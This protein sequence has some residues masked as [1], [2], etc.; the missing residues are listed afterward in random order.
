MNLIKKFI[1]YLTLGFKTISTNHVLFSTL[2]TISFVLI[3]FVVYRAVSLRY[4]VDDIENSI[5]EKIE[6][7]VKIDYPNYEITSKEGAS[8]IAECLKA[9]LTTKQLSEKLLQVSKDLENK[10]NESQYNFSFKYKDL[11]TGFSLSYNSSQPIFAASTIKAPEAIY[12]YKQAEEDKINLQDTI[13]Y[14][15]NYYSEGTGILKNTEFNV[16]YSISKLVEYSII[17]SDNAA[18]L[19]LNNKYKTSNLYN[20]WSHL[21]TTTIFK[22]NNAWGD[23]NANDA[24]IYMEELYNYYVGNNKYSEELLGYF[25]KSWK[26]ISTPNNNIR[27]A[28]KSGWSGSSLHDTALIFDKNPYTLSILTYRGYTEYQNFFDEISTLIYDFHEEYW[29]QK[30]IICQ[31]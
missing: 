15:S 22:Q 23:I 8:Y 1:K 19:M 31:I 11:Y 7:T 9:P 6:T 26:I 13:K 27:I 2:L 24:T 3:S 12:I 14:T 4:K 18:H 5:K 30:L 17:Y 20:F 21:G 10:F 29:N 25:D 16:D 28:S